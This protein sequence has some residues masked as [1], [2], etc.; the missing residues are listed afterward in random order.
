MRPPGTLLHTGTGFSLKSHTLLRFLPE[1]G[2]FLLRPNLHPIAGLSSD[3]VSDVMYISRHSKEFLLRYDSTKDLT[4]DDMAEAIEDAF[5]YDKVI[6]ASSSYDASVF[7]AMEVS[8]KNKGHVILTGDRESIVTLYGALKEFRERDN[9]IDLEELLDQADIFNLL[10]IGAHPCRRGHKL[11]NQ[12]HELLKRLDALDLNGKDI[13]KK[14]ES[15]ARDELI[16]LLKE[17][18]KLPQMIIVTHEAQLENAADN[19]IKVEKENGISKVM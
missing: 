6:F 19:L 18:S 14:G 7:P 10:K 3:S 5:R 4:R 16:N 12:P 15:I 17:M 9:L 8:I 13:F 2:V 11:C 1:A